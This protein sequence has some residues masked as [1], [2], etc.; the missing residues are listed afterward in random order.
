MLP[1][2]RLPALAAAMVAGG[3]VGCS[4]TGPHW[5]ALAPTALA[6]TPAA[7]NVAAILPAAAGWPWVVGGNT[8]T[9]NLP[10]VG[11]WHSG[12]GNTWTRAATK[13]LTLDAPH[14]LIF[15]IAR[16]ANVAIAVGETPGEAHG[17]PR[18][19]IWRS[20]DGSTWSEVPTLR[21]DFGGPI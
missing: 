13:G 1:R 4:A 21:E 14:N 2:F 19:T 6:P 5:R 10:D 8:K 12:N 16:R 3:L 7:V 15:S 18:P 20:I 9:G 17:N 11:L